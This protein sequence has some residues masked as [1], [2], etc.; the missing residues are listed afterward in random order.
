MSKTTRPV[1]DSELHDIAIQAQQN[2]ARAGIT[3]ALLHIENSFIQVIEGPDSAIEKLLTTLLADKRHKD[4]SIIMDRWVSSRDFKNWS[5]GMIKISDDEK[6]DVVREIRSATGPDSDGADQLGFF[7]ESQ[8]FLMM[9][10]VY[11]TNSA[12]RQA[13]TPAPH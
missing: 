1:E 6:T 9:K 8:T 4:M 11:Q 12:L 7:P 5:M 3:G 2:N 10:H 13:Q